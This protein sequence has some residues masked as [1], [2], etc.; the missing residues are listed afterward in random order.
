MPS[1]AVPAATADDSGAPTR[2]WSADA[3]PAALRVAFEYRGDVTLELGDGESVE[4]YVTDVGPRA[5]RLWVRGSTA[6]RE[7]P[8][9]RVRRVALTGRDTA[10][11][12]SFETWKR[13]QAAATAT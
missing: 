12:K 9:A 10:A 7:I 4:G 2:G 8:V 11:G 6:V 13:Q 5:V 1:R 3:S